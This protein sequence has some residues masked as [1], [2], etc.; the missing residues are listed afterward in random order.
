ML[1]FW[2]FSYTNLKVLADQVHYLLF[3][4]KEGEQIDK[5]VE[6]NKPELQKKITAIA[7]AQRDFLNEEI[8]SETN[9]EESLHELENMVKDVGYRNEMDVNKLV[10]YPG[11]N[12]ECSMVQSLE[13]IVADI[14]EDPTNDEAEDD[15]IPLEPVTRKEALS[16]TTTLQNFLLQLENSTPELLAA[17]KKVRDEIQLDLNFKKNQ[18]TIDSDFSKLP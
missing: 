11:E 3:F 15:S 18:V 16:A 4:L 1:M 9:F 7:Y 14:I 5:L 8:S 2:M 17:I 12:D 6:A 10:D 13:E